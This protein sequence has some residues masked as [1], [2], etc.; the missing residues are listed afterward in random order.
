MLERVCRSLG[1]PTRCSPARPTEDGVTP[2]DSVGSIRVV[3]VASGQA[4]LRTNLPGGLEA[5]QRAVCLELRFR[6]VD[7][8]WIVG[9]HGRSCL[10]GQ[11]LRSGPG[12]RFRHPLR[13]LGEVWS[14]Q[15]GTQIG[16]VG[17]NLR[18]D[19]SAFA[20]SKL[21]R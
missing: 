11:L 3:S 19:R 12:S 16:D 13:R 17:H 15:H 9:A 2:A 10:R 6:A 5:A 21:T 8:H 1:S 7:A 18:E 4:R 14:R 20:L